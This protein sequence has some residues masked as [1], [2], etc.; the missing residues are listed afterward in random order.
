MP[1]KIPSFKPGFL[2][3]KV[4]PLGSQPVPIAPQDL[5]DRNQSAPKDNSG[6]KDSG[7]K[8]GK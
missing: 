3:P 7:K 4:R 2:K 1:K 6:K 8:K 5:K